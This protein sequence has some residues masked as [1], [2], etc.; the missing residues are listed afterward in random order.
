MNVITPEWKAP[1]HVRACTTLRHFW[2]DRGDLSSQLAAEREKLRHLL[3][4]REAPIFLNQ[5]HSNIALPAIPENQDATGDAS[6]TR[7]PHRVCVTLTAD[8]LP[9]LITHQ[10]GRSVAAAHAGWRGLAG[11]VVENTFKAMNEAPAEC[12]VWLGP[13]I[14]PQRFEVGNDVVLAFTQIHPEAEACFSPQP[15]QKWLA[16]IYALARVRLARLGVLP[17]NISGGTHCTLTES[18][19]FFSYRRDKERSGRM[20]SL[21][22]IQQP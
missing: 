11:G 3:G 13:A 7:E 21:I 16:D 14:G 9:V 1:A 2:G 20:A 22:W 19:L 10:T 18:D 17:Q 5:T 4:L 15:H 12:L 8:C 6:Y